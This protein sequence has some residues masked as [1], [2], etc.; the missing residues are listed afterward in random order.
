MLVA[1]CELRNRISGFYACET[2]QTLR[3]CFWA[4]GTISFEP[5]FL[6]SNARFL[7]SSSWFVAAILGTNVVSLPGAE[8]RV[9][10]A[11]V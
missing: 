7:L 9:R 6:A 8:S 2:Q 1:S 3:V 5:K 10:P 11:A 4:K